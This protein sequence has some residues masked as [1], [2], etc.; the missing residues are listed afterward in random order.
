MDYNKKHEALRKAQRKI[1]DIGPFFRTE[2]AQYAIELGFDK[3]VDWA[4]S[5]QWISV[6]EKFPEKLEGEIISDYVFVTNGNWYDIM[7]Y[8]FNEKIWLDYTNGRHW[9]VTHW[10]PIPKLNTDIN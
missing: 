3:G 10:M 2:M 5:N 9:G 8:D 1:S 4:L 6:Q 7:R